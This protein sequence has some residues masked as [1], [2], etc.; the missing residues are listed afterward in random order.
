VLDQGNT[1]VDC[2]NLAIA[3]LEADGTLA[4][5]EDEYLSDVTFPELG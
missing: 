5:L 2:L 4:S 1:F 3:E